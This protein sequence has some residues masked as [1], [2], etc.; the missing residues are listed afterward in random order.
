M[1]VT[2][3]NIMKI[4]PLDNSNNYISNSKQVK[5]NNPQYISNP[6]Y[7]GQLAGI[8]KSYISFG[9]GDSLDLYKTFA[10][11]RDKYERDGE[12]QEPYLVKREIL[13]ELERRNPDNKTLIDVHKNVYGDLL[14]ANDLN[15]IKRKYPTFRLVKEA[16]EVDFKDNK[17]IAE[18]KNGNNPIFNNKEDL[19]VQLIKLY[20]GEGFSLSDIAKQ[21]NTKPS[22]ILFIMDKLNI[23]RVTPYYGKILK[24]SDR[25][26]NERFTREMAEKREI[27]AA[28][29][30]GEPYIPRKPLTKEQKQHI[31]ESL[32][33]FYAKNPERISE[34]SERQ[35]E[36]YKKHPEA[37]LI[38]RFVMLKAW[39]MESCAAVRRRLKSFLEQNNIQLEK[40]EKEPSFDYLSR[41]QAE[42]MK[43]FWDTHPYE[44]KKFSKGVISAWE[45]I[46]NH[47]NIDSIKN[48]ANVKLFPTLFENEIKAWTKQEKMKPNSVLKGVDVSDFNIPLAF[49]LF[50]L[51]LVNKT[52][53]YKIINEFFKANKKHFSKF[54]DAIAL[55][56]M[57]IHNYY[58]R[59]NDV[60]LSLAKEVVSFVDRAMAKRTKMDVNEVVKLYADILTIVRKNGN[61]D[62]FN[63]IL[64]A[65]DLV[66][67]KD[68]ATGLN[69]LLVL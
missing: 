13:K 44:K 42:K 46:N 11:L 68:F 43:V 22:T 41:L 64:K 24:L 47:Q 38:F 6:I 49:Q 18:I 10:L 19:S 56:I 34:L 4:L 45:K 7:K 52:D 26:Y 5:K 51:D 61:E 31:S 59:S 50:P 60:D 37:A 29:K 69:T 20:W 17:L 35:K 33:D 12:E 27:I 58:K 55:Q 67:N 40:N 30:R 53:E 9:G 57:G 39:N 14:N 66:Y 21:A 15:E 2:E 28:E 8:P 54:N 1:F 23:E 25:E 62:D 63:K 32:I 48:T 65:Y 16:N 36:F 3:R